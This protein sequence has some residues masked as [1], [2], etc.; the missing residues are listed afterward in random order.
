MNAAPPA[1][2]TKALPRHKWK[3]PETLAVMAKV[4][5]ELRASRAALDAL[6]LPL[7]AAHV[8]MAVQALNQRV[9]RAGPS[10]PGYTTAFSSPVDRVRV[11]KASSPH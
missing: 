3:D 6:D 5:D 4:L 9:P 10:L 11:V 8:D 7:P 2:V 1:P